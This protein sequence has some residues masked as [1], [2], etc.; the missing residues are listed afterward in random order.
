MFPSLPL[1]GE[2]VNG[3]TLFF[4]NINVFHAAA[5]LIRMQNTAANLSLLLFFSLFP[6]ANRYITAPAAADF[7]GLLH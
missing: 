1:G 4:P 6:L 2:N 5:G 3:L 7:N